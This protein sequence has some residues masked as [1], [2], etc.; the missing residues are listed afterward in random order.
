MNDELVDVA[1]VVG[2]QNPW[3]HMAPV[4]AGVVHQSAQGEVHPRG[5][6][7]GQRQR[8]G[9]FPIVQAIGDAIGRGR[10]IRTREHSRQHRRRDAGAGQF[11]ALLDHVRVRNVL[12]TDADFHGHGEVVHQRNELFQQ[13][14][15]EGT[16]MGDGDA[17]SSR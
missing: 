17:V 2:Q 10:Q 6:E 11:I 16:G 12:L 3:L 13:V 1:V 15:A 9:V 4:A 7:Q 14:F 5:V 8:V